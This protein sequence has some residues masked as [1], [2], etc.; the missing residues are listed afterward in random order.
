MS[1]GFGGFAL[2][3]YGGRSAVGS[4]FAAGLLH[5]ALSGH[6]TVYNS[7]GINTKDPDTP[8]FVRPSVQVTKSVMIKATPEQIYP[9]FSRDLER[10]IALSPEIVSLE[11]LGSGLSRWTV[12]TPVGRRSF[13]SQLVK[14]EENRRLA[15]ECSDKFVPHEGEIV[16][17]PGPRGTEVRVSM[18]YHPPAPALA[19][20][21]SRLTGHEPHEALERA[22]YN[23]QSLLEAG[24]V[25]KAKLSNGQA[26]KELVR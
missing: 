13:E 22:L 9:F 5:R 21:L 8:T 20:Q 24:E 10:L 19:A 26:R 1:A 12:V 18:S 25:A 17:T 16:L 7:L 23:L 6:C 2:A 3:R 14:R 11:R 15:W 4:L